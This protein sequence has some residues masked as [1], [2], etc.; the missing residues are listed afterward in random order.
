MATTSNNN[1]SSCL[2]LFVTVDT[3]SRILTTSH[4]QS[5]ARPEEEREEMP[6]SSTDTENARTKRTFLALVAEQV[7][8]VHSV[9]R[10][11]SYLKQTIGWNLAFVVVL[12]TIGSFVITAHKFNFTFLAAIPVAVFCWISFAVMIVSLSQI[13]VSI[14]NIQVTLSRM[15]DQISWSIE[16]RVRIN[17]TLEGMLHSNGFTAFDYFPQIDR[18]MVITVIKIIQMRK[19][20]INLNFQVLLEMISYILILVLTYK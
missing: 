20:T 1:A 14:R 13:P 8:A 5:M 18:T 6:S 9:R 15:A 17:R 11:N 16:E 7:A 12:A 2:V 4:E 3:L 19:Q 10:F